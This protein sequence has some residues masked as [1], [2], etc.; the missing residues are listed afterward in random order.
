MLVA[1]TNLGAK[2]QQILVPDR[3]GRLG[4]VVLGYETVDGVIGGQ[5]SMGAFVGRYA[6]RI[7]GGTFALDGV[8]YRLPH[9]DGN[10]RP[11][12]LHGGP[13]GSRVRVFD[14]IQR[15]SSSVE[16]SLVFDEREDGFPGTVHL[17]V[18]YSVRDDDALFIEYRAE[19]GDKTTVV[20]LTS[21]AFFNL[22]GVPSQSVLA[23]EFEVNA[24][25]VLEI[26]ENLI[27]TGVLR[28]VAG[29]PMDF[30]RPKALGTDIDADYDLLKFGNGYDHAYVTD[31][32]GEATAPTGYEGLTFMARARDESSGRMMEVWSTEPSLQLVSGNSLAGQEPRDRGKGG[33]LFP[34]RSGF[35]V[36]PGHYPD[37]PNH[38]TFPSTVLPAGGTYEGT[39]A[40]RFYCR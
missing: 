27:P 31:G 28:D 17:H 38:P 13:H 10:H 6:N 19:A 12:T 25:K 18:R 23:T 33:V 7:A 36:E 2:I 14:A 21:H 30:R 35:A 9:N 3:Y 8:R 22:A 4:D 11:N 37:S 24:Q 5:P 32:G 40:Y 20:S 34:F 1:I 16:M 29:T 39:I 26:D 15:S